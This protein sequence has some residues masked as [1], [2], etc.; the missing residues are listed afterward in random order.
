MDRIISKYNEFSDKQIFIAIDQI[1]TLEAGTR[2]LINN[3][4]IIS[5]Y[6]NGGELFGES[7]IKM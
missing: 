5:L 4:K 3:K 7:W 1:E 2:E 6:A